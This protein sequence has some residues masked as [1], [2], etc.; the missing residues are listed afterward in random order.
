LLKEMCKRELVS[1]LPNRKALSQGHHENLAILLQ[2]VNMLESLHLKY[3]MFI[4]QNSWSLLKTR[5]YLFYQ[6]NEER[7]RS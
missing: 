1:S 4:N 2:T 3:Q 7:E 5:K 6:K